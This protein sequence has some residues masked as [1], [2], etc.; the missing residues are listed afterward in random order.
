MR[1]LV[2]AVF[3]ACLFIGKQYPLAVAVIALVLYL[4]G[5]D[6]SR[7]DRLDNN[8]NRLNDR[9]DRLDTKLNMIN[10]RLDRLR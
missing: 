5:V 4:D 10:D 1:F 7:F 9:F 6:D 3:V 2:L 8:I